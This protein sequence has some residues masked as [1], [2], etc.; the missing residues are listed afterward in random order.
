M[1]SCGE[2]SLVFLLGIS[3]ASFERLDFGQRFSRHRASTG[4]SRSG[5][6][7]EDGPGDQA[8]HVGTPHAERQHGHREQARQTMVWMSRYLDAA[9][10]TAFLRA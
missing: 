8:Q 2:C 9:L 6:R 3:S 5:Q 4:C 7:R 10:V 1:D